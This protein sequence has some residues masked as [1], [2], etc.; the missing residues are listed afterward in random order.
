MRETAHSI[1]PLL[2]G[3]ALLMLGNGALPTLIAVRL[4]AAGE[5]TWLIGVVM[6]QYYLGIILGTLYGYKLIMTVG[7]IRAFA[8][9][10]STMSAVTLAHAFINDPWAWSAFRF[11]IGACSVGMFM[12]VESW[13]NAR[14]D[15]N[16]RGRVFSLYVITIYLFQ[17]IGQFLIQLPD[18]TGFAIYAVVSVLMSL[19]IVP[20]AVTRAPAPILPK[21]TRFDFVRLWRTSPTGMVVSLF[22]G[23]ILGAFY[24]VGPVF[25]QMSGFDRADTA[26]FMSAVI[27]GGLILQW[28][29]GRFSDGRDRRSFMLFINLCLCGVCL[30]LAFSGIS[31]YGLI[32]LAVFFGGLSGSLYPL[33]V[34]YTNDFLEPEDLV[35]AAGGLVMAYGVGALFGPPVAAAS[36]EIFGKQG[37]FFFCAGVALIAAML[38]VWRGRQREAPSLEDQVDFQVMPRTSPIISELDPRAEPVDHDV[39]V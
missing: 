35:P 5:P 39:S 15:N 7:H 6:A 24:G 27:M 2:V 34:A 21:A 22:S 36:M 30:I 29:M 4:S 32:G 25:A 19:S 33:S 31:G 1:S 38:I 13:L 3:M 9:F 14:A 37:L 17:G 23:L 20:V 12:C 16:S 28:P 18:D 26:F 8:A 11:V 10:G